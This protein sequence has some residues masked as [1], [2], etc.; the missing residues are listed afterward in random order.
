[1]RHHEEACTIFDDGRQQSNGWRQ[2]DPCSDRDSS[3]KHQ[4]PFSYVLAKGRAERQARRRSFLSKSF[5]LTSG[6]C[7][8]CCVLCFEISNVQL[9][10]IP[11][12]GHLDGERHCIMAGQGRRKR[13]ASSD[14]DESDDEEDRL[15][16][17]LADHQQRNVSNW[18][19]GEESSSSNN[20][21]RAT[22]RL[23]RRDERRDMQ[24][25]K[26]RDENESDLDDSFA[27]DTVG[28]GVTIST[29]QS[30]G[31]S[32]PSSVSVQRVDGLLLPGHVD[33]QTEE[34]KADQEE[35]EQDLID[36]KV[37]EAAQG[38]LGDFVRLDGDRPGVSR[39]KD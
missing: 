15:E 25:K 20:N 34:E 35:K 36:E 10:E 7:A 32:L 17:M 21:S 39:C 14:L 28:T 13:R 5:S 26:R 23:A 31:T 9:Q 6:K 29:E 33:V 2:K 27:V 1:V 11:P 22:N 4:K 3:K 12:L 18:G 19:Q 38:E 8:T 16:K 24:R 37:D 30:N